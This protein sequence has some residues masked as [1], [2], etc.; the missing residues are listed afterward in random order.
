MSRPAKIIIDPVALLH[1]V[2]RVREMAPRS[3][4]IAMVK[5]YAYGHGLEQIAGIL[6]EHVDALG[7]ACIEEG[8]ALR[9]AGLTSIPIIL[10]EGVFHGSEL[11]PAMQHHFTLVVHRQGQI[12]MLEKFPHPHSFDVWLKINTGMNRLGFDPRHAE[13][14]WLRLMSCPR[15][16]KPIGLMSHFAETSEPNSPGM[17][18]QLALFNKISTN[19]HGPRSLAK[20][21]AVLDSPETHME[22]LRPGIILYGVSPWPDRTGRDHGLLPVMTFCSELIAVHH[23]QKNEKIGYGGT[24]SCPE[25]MRVGVVAAGYGDGYPQHAANGTPVLVNGQIC[26]LI[27]RVSMDMLTVDLR[28]QPEARTGDPVVLWG[29]G[30]PVEHVAQHCN[31]SAYELLTRMPGQRM[32]LRIEPA[33]AAVSPETKGEMHAIV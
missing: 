26:P 23:V 14:A 10:M 19:L 12:D 9:G 3:R 7:V 8:I 33:P 1:N 2:G 20:S 22:W 21:A 29:K 4:I 28:T 18:R 15:V 31:S 5:S 13:A 16:R 27:G 24:Y 11:E 6:H 25:D 30:L 32:P 17:Q